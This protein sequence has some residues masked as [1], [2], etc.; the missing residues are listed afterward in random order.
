MNFKEFHLR[1]VQEI[2]WPVLSKDEE[3]DRVEAQIFDKLRSAI[4]SADFRKDTDA[5]LDE[6]RRIYDAEAERRRGA[7]NKA[8]IYLAAITALIPVLASLVANLWSE[9]TSALIGGLTL[10]IF[11]FS[12]LYLVRAGGWAFKT[13]KVAISNQ[14][15]PGDIF[16]SWKKPNPKQELAKQL[17][18]SVIS[19][20]RGVNNKVACITMAHQ[21]LLRAFLTFALLLAIQAISPIGQAATKSLLPDARP[22]PSTRAFA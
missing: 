16:V 6:A 3:G 21:F 22:S 1:D 15:S 9:K 20:Y 2:I 14:T 19:N 12:T 4:N 17:C 13:L 7:D 8:G 18:R 10:V 11:V 5:A